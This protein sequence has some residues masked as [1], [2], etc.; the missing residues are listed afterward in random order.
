MTL[1]SDSLMHDWTLTVRV[2]SGN[3]GNLPI[4]TVP[5]LLPLYIGA[6]TMAAYLPAKGSPAVHPNMHP[7]NK[8]VSSQYTNVAVYHKT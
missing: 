2:L 5:V 3:S 8:D 7:Q 4:E 1:S 6:D